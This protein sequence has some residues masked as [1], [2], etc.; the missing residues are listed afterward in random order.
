MNKSIDKESFKG[1]IRK[2][3]IDIIVV[4]SLLLLSLIVLLVIGLTRKDGAYAEVTADGEVIASYPLSADGEYVLNGGTNIL[5]IKDGTAYM[6][7]S[8]CPDHVCENTGKVRY[9]GETIICLPNKLTVT[10]KGEPS[11]DSVDLV[12]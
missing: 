10:V 9:V 3:R 2:H 1:F 4:A 6:S 8:S 5:T 12:S 11:D 7:Y